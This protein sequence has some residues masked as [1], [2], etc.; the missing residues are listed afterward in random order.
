MEERHKIILGKQNPQWR[1]SFT[2][3]P[4]FQRDL[5]GI[6]QRYLPTKQAL[7]II[8]LRRVGK[9]VLLHQLMQSLKT[10]TLNLCYISF[11]DRDFQEYE[12]A[13]ELVEHFLQNSDP[14]HQRYLFLD[15]IQKVSQWS[16]LIK[17]LYDT[18]KNLKIIISGSSSLELKQSKESL[19]GRLLT[20]PLPILA[21]REFV[22]YHQLPSKISLQRLQKEYDS[23]FLPEKRKYE[24]LFQQYV[25]QGA[26]PELLNNTDEEYMK[27]YISEVIDKIISDVSKSIDPAKEK[28][29]SNLILLFCKSTGRLFEV[30]NLSSLLQVHR[31][32]VSR[33]I[34]LLEKTFLIRVGYNFTP[35]IAKRLRVSKKGYLAHSCIPIALLQY[36]F[37]IF[38]MEGSERGHLVETAIIS[39]MQDIAFWRHQQAEVDLVLKDKTPVEI[40]FQNGIQ[41]RDVEHIQKFLGKYHAPR[42]II[43]TKDLFK[44]SSSGPQEILF[45]PAWCYLLLE[46][47]CP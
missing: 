3:V 7:A 21:F 40:K 10:G 30:N 12:L 28:E 31:N 23:Q 16:D 22:R 20:F 46:D 29:I 37:D 13:S 33:Y 17:T 9:T 27:K 32:T 11:D 25:L 26:F 41:E 35:S 8:G 6:L 24:L 43:V 39:N 47:V 38:N 5:F 4:S 19:A 2:E 18:E 14:Q 36:P 44:I 45:L 34:H 1:G 42:G 15:E